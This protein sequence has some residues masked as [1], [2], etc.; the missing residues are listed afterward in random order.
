LQFCGGDRADRVPGVPL[1]VRKGGRAHWTK[2]YFNPAAFVTRH[3]GTFGNSGRDIMFNPPGFNTDASLM[4]NWSVLEKY[5]LQLRLE[6]FNAFNHPIMGG[7]D[8]W[9]NDGTFGEVNNG[10]GTATNA[11]RVGQAALKFTF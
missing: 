4:K 3:D 2:Q 7:P 10:H 5:T 9:P 6:L 1:D 8:T 11:S